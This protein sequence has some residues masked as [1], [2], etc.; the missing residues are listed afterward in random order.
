M[1]FVIFALLLLVA[2]GYIRLQVRAAR[3]WEGLFGF[4]GKAPLA[5]WAL[6]SALFAADI[7]RDPTSHSLWPFEVVMGLVL[8]S[9]YLMAI[10]GM[11]RIAG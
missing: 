3:D 11:R 9:L 6:W 1:D 8:A 7:M 2:A 5:G 10:S 4:A